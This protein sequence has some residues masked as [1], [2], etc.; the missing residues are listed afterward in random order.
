MR[1]ALLAAAAVLTVALAGAN[2]QTSTPAAAPATG[3]APASADT[4]G[5][6]GD[7]G[8]IGCKLLAPQTGS[9]IGSRRSCQTQAEWE[10]H[11]RQNQ[12][13]LSHEQTR[14][15]LFSTPSH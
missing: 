6:T 5:S 10:A 9:R 11:E 1:Y 3:A 8:K 7:P 13:D 15:G 14:G 12:I 4:G 2:A